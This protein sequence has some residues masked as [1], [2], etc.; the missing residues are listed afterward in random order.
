MNFWSNEYSA[1][2]SLIAMLLFSAFFSCVETALFSASNEQFFRLKNSRKE[3]LK[4]IKI[5][6]QNPTSIL[7]TILLGNLI[8]NIL[9]FCISVS[10]SYRFSDYYGVSLSAQLG[11]LVLF[12]IIIFG[13]IIPKSIGMTFA[14]R[15][16][17]TCSV[18]LYYWYIFIKPLRIALEK[19]ILLLTPKNHNSIILTAAELKTLIDSTRGDDGFGVQEKALVEDIITLPEIAIRELMIPRVDQVFLNGDLTVDDAITFIM[20][21]PKDLFPVYTDDKENIIGYVELS[22]LFTSSIQTNIIDLVHPINF[23]PETKKAD[24]MLKD[25]IDNNL[26]LVGVV[27]EYGGLSGTLIVKDVLKELIGDFDHKNR[28]LIEKI[29]QNTYRLKGYLNIREW[30]ELFIGMI[31]KERIDELALDTVSGLVISLLKKMPR[32]GDQVFLGNLCFTV[33][34]VIANRIENIKL[35][36]IFNQENN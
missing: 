6:D 26:K 11:I 8:V 4:I 21:N 32:S 15:V 25:F 16:I 19:I 7:I 27:D 33:E 31:P 17:K 28:P 34:E 36:L 35:E 9:F 30:R 20:D 13:E 14:T 5:L 22:D 24:E 29:D 3:I 18:F 1:I 23:V 2:L 12:L 10:I